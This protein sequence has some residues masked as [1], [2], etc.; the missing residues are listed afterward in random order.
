MSGNNSLVS[1]FGSRVDDSKKGGDID[2]LIE[3]E[4]I[5]NEFSQIV[6]LKAKLQLSLDMQKIDIIIARDPTR[7]IEIEANKTKIML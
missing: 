4:K 7:P 2:L 6:N 5:T 3:P 1:L